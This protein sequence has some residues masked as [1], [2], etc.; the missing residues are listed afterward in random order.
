VEM[1]SLREQSKAPIKQDDDAKQMPL[2]LTH[3]QKQFIQG[4]KHSQQ[5]CVL[6]VKTKEPYTLEKGG[7]YL[8]R[9][10]I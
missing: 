7:K 6:C 2:G 5:S 1:V 4:K 3:L 10:R 8:N 9:W